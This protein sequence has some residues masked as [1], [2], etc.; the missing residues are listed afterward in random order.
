MWRE[1][2]IAVSISRTRNALL[3]GSTGLVQGVVLQPCTARTA[4]VT[5]FTKVY[6]L[7]PKQGQNIENRN[8]GGIEMR[9]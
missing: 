3:P 7:F 2:A 4:A 9:E 5:V 6:K 8:T 1:R